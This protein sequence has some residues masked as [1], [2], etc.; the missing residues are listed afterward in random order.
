VSRIHPRFRTPYVAVFVH[1]LFVAIVSVNGSFAQL[2]IVA[3]VSLLTLYLLCALAAYELQRRDVR[4]A[5]TPFVMPGRGT[6]PVLASLVI[7]WLLSQA[8]AREFAL[9]AMALLAASLVYVVRRRTRI[10]S[11]MTIEDRSEGAL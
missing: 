1:A 10:N 8:T 11:A 4:I 9:E 6:I 2:L 3:N 5:A 7:V